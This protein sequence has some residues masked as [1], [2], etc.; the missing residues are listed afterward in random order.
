MDGPRYSWSLKFWERWGGDR[1]SGVRW[2]RSILGV[3][4]KGTHCLSNSDFIKRIHHF[5]GLISYIKNICSMPIYMQGFARGTETEFNARRHGRI[6]YFE[7][8]NFFPF[9]DVLTPVPTT[10][11]F[12]TYNIYI[13]IARRLADF[14]QDGCL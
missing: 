11:D 10:I 8:R 7:L 2:F 4:K 12:N 5:R 9:S 1:G 14:T 13:I 6:A 3:I